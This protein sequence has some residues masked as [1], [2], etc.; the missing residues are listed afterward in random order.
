M[1]MQPPFSLTL[2]IQAAGSYKAVFTYDTTWCHSLNDP[3]NFPI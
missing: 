1:N 2:T 3:L